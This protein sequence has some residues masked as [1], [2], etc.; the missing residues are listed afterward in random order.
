[1]EA[2]AIIGQVMGM[3]QQAAAQELNT[4]IMK[5]SMAQDMQ[6]GQAIVDMMKTIT[7]PA[8]YGAS[9]NTYA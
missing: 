4:S 9:L 7:P 2:S 1:M 3:Q 5:M 6:Q 8:V